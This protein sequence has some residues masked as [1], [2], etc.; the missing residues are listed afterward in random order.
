MS[1]AIG[2]GS[3]NEPTVDTEG[4][5]AVVNECGKSE[6]MRREWLCDM[7]GRQETAIKVD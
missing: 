7:G 2:F 5:N 1:G 6:R 4:A 3:T